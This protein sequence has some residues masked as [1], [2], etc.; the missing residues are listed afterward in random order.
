M[1]HL[2]IRESRGNYA[3][4]FAFLALFLP[5]ATKAGYPQQKAPSGGVVRRP[6][7]AV[8]YQ[9]GGGGTRVDLI[10]TKLSPQANGEAK[11]EARTG[12]TNIELTGRELARPE[13]FGNEFLTYVLWA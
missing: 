8:G 9:V 12:I 4:V 1:K 10:G 5:A 13:Q 11:V 2:N 3:I 6:I 7:T